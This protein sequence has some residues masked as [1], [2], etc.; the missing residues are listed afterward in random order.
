M[1]AA[2]AQAYKAEAGRV[3]AALI[4]QFRDFNLAEEALQDAMIEAARTWPNG[5]TPSNTGA[6]LLAVSRRRALDRLR[7]VARAKDEALLQNLALIAEDQPEDEAAQDIPD[8]RLRLIFTCCHPALAQEAQVALTLR[9]LCGL[10]AREIA[11]AF[12]VPHATMN[13][14]LTR[15]K[16][17]IRHAGIPYKVPEGPDIPARLN[18]VLSV[19]YLIFNAGYAPR[20][21]ELSAEALRLCEVLHRLQPRPETAGLW[22]LME[23]HMARDP[24]LL[25][26]DNALISLKDQNRI[27]WDHPAI[28]RAKTRLLHALAQ[29]RP[30]PYQIQAAI[31]ALHCEAES[32]ASTDWPQILALY[33]ALYKAAPTPVVALNRAVANAHAGAPEA[34]LAEVLKLEGALQN[35]QPFHAAKAELLAQ[36]GHPAWQAY[37]RA[38][39]LTTAPE[40]LAF[41][42][43][44]Q[45]KTA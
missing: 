24:A 31:S 42:R 3:L 21:P 16:A 44:K 5:G 6:W 26:A 40:E 38:I 17:K 29:S 36:C 41:L 34:A 22:A 27:L 25:D 45:Q 12:L 20:E 30:G 28:A 14:R 33:D 15:A 43:R 37:A 19:I 23:L 13:Q 11:R 39:S 7:K 8:E 10:S 4:A 9:T 2:L 18:A 35:Y 32:F 1:Q